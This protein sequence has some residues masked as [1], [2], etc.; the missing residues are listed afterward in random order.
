MSSVAWRNLRLSAKLALA[1]GS[2]ILLI[3]A[4][5][6]WSTSGLN[7]IAVATTDMQLAN[8]LQGEFLQREV[9][10][11][12]W[13]SALSAYINDEHVN[14]LNIQLDHTKCGF[15]K[16]YYGIG[17]KSAEK[18]YPDL[19]RYLS[20][21]EEPHRLL[22]HSAK[23]VQ[24]KL[25]VNAKGATLAEAKL[26]YAEHTQPSLTAVQRLLGKM[27]GL[28]DGKAQ[29]TQAQM[30]E[31]SQSTKAEVIGASL[32]AIA[33]AILLA[34]FITRSI[35][36]SMHKGLE[37]AQAVAAGDLNVRVED[38]TKDE[39][40]KLLSSLGKMSVKLAQ[41]ITQVR[42]NAENLGSASAQVS[43]T[44]QIISQ[45]ASEQAAS[46]EETSASMEQMGVSIN[47]NSENARTTDSI[48]A[49]AAKSAREGGEAVGETVVAMK[50]IADK[51]GIIEDIAYKT[52]MLALNAAIEAARA[53]EHGKG[54]AVVASEVRK[55]AERSQT[56]ASEIG[57]LA[58]SSVKVAERAGKILNEIV[59]VINKTANHVQ[60]ITAA[61][62]EQAGDAGQI[63]G[64]MSQL[65][66][67]TQQNAAASEELAATAQEMRSQAEDLLHLIGF[68]K[69]DEVPS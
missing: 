1:F 47:M 50:D 9:D 8:S 32:V 48:A 43:S 17:A 38:T 37:M 51:I 60:E 20:Q 16:W 67:V 28:V 23:R 10:H 58:G 3:I 49:E 36:K 44:A 55:L 46:V 15:G 5:A 39:V 21:I 22:H 34:L 12:K 2:V 33:L 42:S 31:I 6:F 59:P 41:V 66:Q 69:L 56:A 61:S 52:N 62:A 25:K 7:S 11:L 24:D 54:F 18:A 13:A 26:I 63:T 45:G 53:G 64:A 19:G 30:E 65:D 68:F 4:V 29:D 40:G 14:E 57:E 35:T 27:R